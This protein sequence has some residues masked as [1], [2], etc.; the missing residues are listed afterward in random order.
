[1]DELIDYEKFKWVN[2][3][4]FVFDSGEPER[5]YTTLLFYCKIDDVND[6]VPMI[7]KIIVKNGKNIEHYSIGSL[8]FGNATIRL[9]NV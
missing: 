8:N 6:N 2:M 5:K 7:D 9:R 4:I 3:T 1:M